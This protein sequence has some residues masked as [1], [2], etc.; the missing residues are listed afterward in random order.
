MANY[1]TLVWISN[2]KFGIQGLSTSFNIHNIFWDEI[3][4]IKKILGNNSF[5]EG[6]WIMNKIFSNYCLTIDLCQS[7]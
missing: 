1:H 4:P 2:I 6:L 3:V 7:Q 5:D